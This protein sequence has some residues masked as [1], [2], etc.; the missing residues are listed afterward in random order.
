MYYRQII[1]ETGAYLN[2]NG[3]R[4][5]LIP[6]GCPCPTTGWTWFDTF[7]ECIETWG[8]TYDPL[9]ELETQPEI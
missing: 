9:P 3:E 5:G 1:D 6:A 7:K 8:L 4:V 2:A